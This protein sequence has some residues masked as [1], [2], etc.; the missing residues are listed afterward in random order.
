MPNRHSF[1]SL[2]I[3]T[4]RVINETPRKLRLCSA[5]GQLWNIFAR[6]LE[7]IVLVL[8]EERALQTLTNQLAANQTPRKADICRVAEKQRPL[9][10]CFRAEMLKQSQFFAQIALRARQTKQE[11]RA[12]T[13]LDACNC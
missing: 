11:K 13:K 10:D 5:A 9:V 7:L 6:G 1:A 2:L 4:F 3:Q 8:I 12:K